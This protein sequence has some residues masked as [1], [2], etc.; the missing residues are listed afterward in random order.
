MK[1]DPKKTLAHMISANRTTLAMRVDD[2]LGVFF[3]LILSVMHGAQIE[4]KDDRS[5]VLLV[6]SDE[7][8]VTLKDVGALM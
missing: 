3:E 7:K 2:F 1:K 5:L 6:S 4:D 8:E